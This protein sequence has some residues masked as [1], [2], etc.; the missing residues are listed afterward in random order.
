[1]AKFDEN[2]VANANAVKEGHR[3]YANVSN[4]NIVFLTLF[5]LPSSV[6]D[7]PFMSLPREE[8]RSSKH[9]MSYQRLSFDQINVLP[10]ISGTLVQSH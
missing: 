2:T 9:L 8:W 10:M 1:M 6:S 5:P 4:R 3:K 7:V